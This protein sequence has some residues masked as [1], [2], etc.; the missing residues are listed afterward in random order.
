MKTISLLALLTLALF[1]SMV[2]AQTSY[3]TENHAPTYFPDKKM[4]EIK[5]S[6]CNILQKETAWVWD[7]EK[8]IYGN[9]KDILV[10]DDRIEFVIKKQKTT[11]NFSDLGNFEIKIDGFFMT[12]AD[13]KYN[14]ER[15]EL[16]LG[17]L[18]FNY[19]MDFQSAMQ[20]ANDLFFIQ[21]QVQKVNN[22]QLKNQMSSELVLFEPFAAQYRAL[23]VKPPIPEEQREL[24]VQAN[25]FNQKKMYEKAIEL[26]S[27]AIEVDQ[28][29]YPAAY[30]NLALLSAQ[31][32]K[33]D[34]AIYY[35]KK[36]L[37]LEPESS[38]AR[39]AQD[40][41]YEWKISVAP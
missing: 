35:M 25:S 13:G 14:L 24:I 2:N 27:K 33:Y 11:I 6:I 10:L 15:Y 28:T 7:K 22:Q 26:Y 18:T 30:S 4:S 8:E 29:A 16:N 23:K 3:K 9:P 39:S 38:D 36:Y 19:K 32:Q 12:G 1:T 37:L 34:A 41:I 20:I 31:I 40:K 21:K 5:A 17:K